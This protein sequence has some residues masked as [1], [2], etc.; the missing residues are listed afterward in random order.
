MKRR[1]AALVFFPLAS[2][3]ALAQT[4]DVS[5]SGSRASVPGPTEHFTGTVTVTPLFAPSASSNVAGGLVEFTP[6]ARSAWHTHPAGQTLIVTEG[7][8]A[9]CSRKTARRSKSK[10]VT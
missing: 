8:W 3:A 5:R 4:I 6:G 7:A 10:Q 2:V 1:L 9:G